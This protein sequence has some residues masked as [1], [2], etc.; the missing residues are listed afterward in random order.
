MMLTLTVG[1]VKWENGRA[2][3]RRMGLLIDRFQIPQRK[4]LGDR[5]PNFW[6]T[7]N[8]PWVMTNYLT[9]RRA[10]TGE[11]FCYIA[12]THGELNAVR[13]LCKTYGSHRRCWPNELPIIELGITHHEP[14]FHVVGW[15]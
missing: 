2:V 12:T 8:D 6:S 14:A 9:L 15:T 10:E 5:D 13:A 11:E 4:D 7:A 1:F 3:A